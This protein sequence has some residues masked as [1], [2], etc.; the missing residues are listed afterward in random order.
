MLAAVYLASFF[1][2]VLR[3]KLLQLHVSILELIYRF[4]KLLFAFVDLLPNG[5]Q[6]G[7][8]LRLFGQPCL[9]HYPCSTVL[10][11][12][13]SIGNLCDEVFFAVG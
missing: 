11:C 3:R 8:F 6:P 9:R 5:L 10:N 7:N 2:S 4:Q 13:I 12:W 1:H